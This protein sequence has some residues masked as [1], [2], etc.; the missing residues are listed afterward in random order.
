MRLLEAKKKFANII[1]VE[2]ESQ[3]AENFIEKCNHRTRISYT[4]NHLIILSFVSPY[5]LFNFFAT[6]FV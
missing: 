4:P 5:Q 1:H 2:K 6:T 3:K